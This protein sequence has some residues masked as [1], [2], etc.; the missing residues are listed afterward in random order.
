M[1]PI[2]RALCSQGS[3]I[4]NIP[5]GQL[6]LIEWDL[7]MCYLAWDQER[8]AIVCQVCS[9]TV[10][11]KMPCL[12]EEIDRESDE[13]K[14]NLDDHSRD[15][16]RLSSGTRAHSFDIQQAKVNLSPGG[17]TGA[18]EEQRQVNVVQSQLGISQMLSW[19]V[20]YSN[21]ICN[22]NII[23]SLIIIAKA[24]SHDHL[25]LQG[26]PHK[27]LLSLLHLHCHL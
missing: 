25:S 18:V 27:L 13:P 7:W 9:Q 21:Y 20:T 11:N 5:R 3:H 10:F 22:N 24:R 6:F 17:I 15:D 8:W 19:W 26:S 23:I 4:P 16:D 14:V 12:D 2:S 1:L